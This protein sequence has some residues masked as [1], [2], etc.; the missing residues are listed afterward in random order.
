MRIKTDLR[1]L[2]LF[3]L[4]VP[5][6]H[7]LDLV[8]TL[9]RAEK[10]DAQMQVA[11]ADYM[12][13]QENSGISQSALL[14]Q[15]SF[16]AFI[17]ENSTE[18]TNSTTLPDSDTDFSTDGFSLS[19]NQVIY[20]Q[21]FWNT[22]DQSDALIAQA[23]AIY[24]S[25]RQDLIIRAT[26]AYFIVLGAQDNLEF[27]RAEKESAARQLEQ[28]TERFN[29]GLIAITDVHEAQANFDS[30]VAQ[31]ILAVNT[32]DNS[33]ESLRVIINDP[34]DEL[35]PLVEEFPLK[36]PEPAD[37]NEW[38]TQ[39]LA[40]NFDLKAAMANLQAAKDGYD[41]SK[42]GHYPT[43]NL[44]ADYSSE[45]ADGNALGLGGRDTES[46]NVILS[47]D[48]PLYEGGSTSAKTRQSA[49]EVDGAQALV[50][51]QRR[52]TIQESRTA[53]LGVQ[54]AIS[55]VKAYKQVLKSSKT[56]LEATQAGFDAGTRTSV[57]VLVVE[58]SLYDS[59][60]NY[61]R[62]KYDYLL[63]V[64]E[65]KRAAGTLTAMDIK[66]INQWLTD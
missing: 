9:T 27:A 14:P 39:A 23:A 55:S 24:A 25:A 57:D 66:D 5:T 53:Y 16:R 62:S 11:L 51:Q 18:I 43:V 4:V 3:L 12:A 59:E 20:N 61:A 50:D 30:A 40:E 10:H 15:I 49:A 36:G 58:G 2:A 21:Q 35:K 54:T 47:L 46:T 19:L 13:V 37:I 8:E 38:Q 45:S 29:V 31:E 64:L 44:R 41:S 32:L 48:V 63:S 22:M 28:S 34:L 33:K 6:A 56:A 52:L 65:L 60:R 17:A 26:T 42:A 7:A 1:I